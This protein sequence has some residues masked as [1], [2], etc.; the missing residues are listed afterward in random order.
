MALLS[1][2][3][4]NTPIRTKFMDTEGKIDLRLVDATISETPTYDAEVTAFP[5][6]DGPDVT[7]NIALRPITL[8]IDGVISET[9]ITLK[10]TAASLVTSGAVAAAGRQGGFNPQLAGIAGGFLGASIFGDTVRGQD[11]DGNERALNPADV[12][13]KAIEDIWR[14]KTLFTIVTKRRKFDNMDLR[15]VTFPRVQN[16]GGSLRFSL[17]AQQIRIVKPESVLIK[18]IATGQ[19]HGAASTSLGKQ[20]TEAATEKEKQSGSLLFQGLQKFGV[21]GG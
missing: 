11:A 15:N 16:D 9:P 20:A 7:D 18:N 3:T 10:G 14:K 1:F 2:L 4:G 17:Q 5:V 13:R 6:E 12:A 21:I 8:Q 19:A